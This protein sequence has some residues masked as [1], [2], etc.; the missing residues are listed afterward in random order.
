MPPPT[1]HQI[2]HSLPLTLIVA[3][4][5]IRVASSTPIENPTRLGIGLKGTLPWPRIKTDMSFF[6]RA[7]SRA[8][9]PGTTNAIIMGRK[10]YDSVPKNLRPLGK[11]ISVIV[12]RDTTGAVREGVLKEL[13]ARKAKMA[14]TAKAKAEGAAGKEAVTGGGATEE[15]I[16]DALVTHSLDAALSELDAVYGSSG[17]LGKIY[18][19]GGAEIYG[20]ALRM[21]MP[22]GE[23]QSR[24]PIRI[25]MTKVVRKA[26]DDGVAKEFECDTSFPV[27]GLGVEHGWRTASAQEVSEWVGETVTGEWIQ[28]GEVE[29]QMVGY[30]R[31]D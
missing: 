18:V 16:T 27:E 10:T 23:Q 11:R 19:I 25:V 2:P 1:T 3:T 12:T 5:P 31:L 26:G 22:V 4:T 30:E 20:A 17:R 21:K 7:T 14:E 24:R 15:P 13:E 6:A 9:A 29:V 8:P 28:D